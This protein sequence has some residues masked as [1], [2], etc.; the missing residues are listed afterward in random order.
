MRDALGIMVETR[1]QP[2]DRQQNGNSEKTV[3][4]QTNSKRINVDK[5]KNCNYAAS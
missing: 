2:K 3:E 5:E 4:R 1:G